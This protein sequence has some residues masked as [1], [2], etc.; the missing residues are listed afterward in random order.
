MTLEAGQQLLHYRLIE[1][2]GEGGMGVVWRAV[3]TK[4]ERDVAVKILPEVVAADPDRLARFEREAK[5]VAALAHPNILA[6]YDFGRDDDT[7]YMVTELLDGESLRERLNEGALPP[8]KA[9]ELARQVARA[10]VR[11]GAAGAIAG[12]PEAA[13]VPGDDAVALR[14]LG[15][16]L[17]PDGV[18]AAVAVTQHDRLGRLARPGRARHLEVDLLTVKVEEVSREV[19]A[20]HVVEDDVENDRD[21]GLVTL[22]DQVLQIIGGA[23]RA[24]GR[25]LKR[26][27]V[28]PGHLACELGERHQLDDVDAELRATLDDV[29]TNGMPQD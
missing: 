20:T 29:A 8:R 4:L 26:R 22:V 13:L 24:L 23:V 14:E 6:V 25:E 10:R 12:A 7:T 19:R 15:H 2:I 9:A 18:V 3:D 5:S 21:A 27:I 17:E 28:A 1:K 11:A 16:L